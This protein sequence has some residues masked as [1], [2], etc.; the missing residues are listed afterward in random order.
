MTDVLGVPV[1]RQ[2]VRAH[3]GAQESGDDAD[4]IRRPHTHFFLK[5][6]GGAACVT[7]K[8]DSSHVCARRA[9]GGG[10]TVAVGRRGGA[11]LRESSLLGPSGLFSAG[12]AAVACVHHNDD[13]A[14]GCRTMD[15]GREMSASTV[16]DEQRTVTESMSF[17]LPQSSNEPR[18]SMKIQV[19][20]HCCA[21]MVVGAA[22]STFAMF[23]VV[24]AAPSMPV[25]SA[26]ST[27]LGLLLGTSLI[28]GIF[29]CCI[30]SFNPRRLPVAN[31]PVRICLC[32]FY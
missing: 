10:R 28:T 23:A 3:E 1:E 18:R 21:G 13:S 22:L 2:L 9:R 8:G 7:L 31:T 17:E 32:S 30:T 15:V 11:D 16:S 26:L 5:K 29:C 12:A 24:F 20:C 14:L 6:K 25:P 4:E 19:C 27:Q